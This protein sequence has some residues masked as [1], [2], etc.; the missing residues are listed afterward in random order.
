MGRQ[1]VE[2]VGQRLR[3]MGLGKDKVV[4]LL[5]WVGLIGIL[6]MALSEWLP[7]RD[8]T[9]SVTAVT[10]DQVEQA[11]EKRITA[12]L[13]QVEGVGSCQVMV[14][15]ESGS[16]T[17]YAADET[18]SVGADGS[19]SVSENYLL[20][21]TEGGP[22]GL[23]LTRIQPTVKGVAVVCDGGSDAAV[24]QRVIQVVSTAFHISQRR[25]CV[26]GAR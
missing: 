24:Q 2:S 18:A 17:V 12:L 14:T 4:R 16:R 20:V 21:E 23:L 26:V 25:V 1:W 10:E 19:S 15:L 13:K 9:A 7:G 6:L 8:R 5:V 3:I 22:V 11:L